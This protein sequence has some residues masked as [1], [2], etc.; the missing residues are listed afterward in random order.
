MLVCGA[1]ALA[2]MLSILLSLEAGPRADRRRRSAS[3]RLA[4]LAARLG[5]ALAVRPLAGGAGHRR[6]WPRSSPDGNASARA[7][8]GSRSRR[9]SSRLCSLRSRQ[10]GSGAARGR[11]EALVCLGVVRRACSRSA[12]SRSSCSRRTASGT[13]S[14]RQTSRPLQIESFGAAVLLVA[15][16]AGGLGI[17]MRSSHG[18][19]NL[20]GT[21]PDALAAVQTVVQAAALV[22][23]WIWF[24]RGPVDARAARARVGGGGLRVRRLRQGALAAVP[25]LADPARAARPRPARAGGERAA[26]DGARGH[27]GL[28]PVPLLGPRAALRHGRRRGSSWPATSCWS[29]CSPC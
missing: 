14:R 13:A 9:S 18:S 17:T 5:R 29:R 3:R 24:A 22:A 19:Q 20:V 21:A 16:V 6:R 15:H 10:S 4:P 11:R 8:S 25:D 27:P 12:S 7:C 26:G 1:L 2:F 23:T 28:V